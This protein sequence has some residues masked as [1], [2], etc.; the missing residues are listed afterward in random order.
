MDDV[1]DNPDIA[2]LLSSLI[3]ENVN[4][5]P[6]VDHKNNPHLSNK[7][8]LQFENK[9]KYSLKEYFTLLR[10]RATHFV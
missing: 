6:L 3:A 9:Q 10:L 2:S 7:F 1:T 5:T 8:E 4:R